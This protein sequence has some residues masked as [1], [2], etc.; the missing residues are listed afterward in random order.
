MR[1]ERGNSRGPGRSSEVFSGRL[2]ALNCAKYLIAR[3]RPR[4]CQGGRRGFEPLLP[5][6]SLDWWIEVEADD[7]VVDLAPRDIGRDVEGRAPCVRGRGCQG[8]GRRVSRPRCSRC[9]EGRPQPNVIARPRVRPHG[10][11]HLAGQ[12]VVE[13]LGDRGRL[14]LRPC[15]RSRARASWAAPRRARAPPRAPASAERNVV[16]RRSI[17]FQPGPTRSRRLR[18]VGI[19]WAAAMRAARTLAPTADVCLKGRAVL[20]FPVKRAGLGRDTVTRTLLSWPLTPRDFWPYTPCTPEARPDI[21]APPGGLQDRLLGPPR[22]LPPRRRGREADC[23]RNHSA[24]E[25]PTRM[26]R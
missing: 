15:H 11:E 6:Q 21:H 9:C 24:A 3:C 8:V 20:V 10:R 12:L 4:P 16:R 14:D 19:S 26:P 5:S 2:A 7:Q 25:V 13:T 17:G 18:R 1:E 23:K 22:L